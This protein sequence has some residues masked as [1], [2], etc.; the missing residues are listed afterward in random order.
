MVMAM[1]MG[2]GGQEAVELCATLSST[3]ATAHD[4]S[5]YNLQLGAQGVPGRGACLMKL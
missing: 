1:M 2:W 3:S 4:T 5:T